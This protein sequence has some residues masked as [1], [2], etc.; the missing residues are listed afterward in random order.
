MKIVNVMLNEM[1]QFIIVN[2]QSITITG[3]GG[4]LFFTLSYYGLKRYV[5]SAERERMIQAK[6]GILD[7]LESRIISK[8]SISK[9][10]IYRLLKAID[11]EHSVALSSIVSP[12]SLLEDLQLRFEKSRHLDSNQKEEYCKKLEEI[13]EEISKG[14]KIVSVPVKYSEI[15]DLLTENIKS[16]KSKEALTTLELLK[17]KIWEKEEFTM[18]NSREPLFKLFKVYVRILRRDP[19]MVPIGLLFYIIMIMIVLYYKGFFF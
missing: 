12:S 7:I 18:Y 9:T 15:T 14:E 17:K 13:V 19:W 8:H 1:W 2:W 5:T 16:N 4:L 3:G 11:R 10:G 6:N